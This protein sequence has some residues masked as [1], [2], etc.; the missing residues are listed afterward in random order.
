MFLDSRKFKNKEWI[1]CWDR[2]PIF[3]FNCL[4][5]GYHI[6]FSHQKIESWVGIFYKEGIAQ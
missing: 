1:L 4:G 6:N 2:I 3:C 5:E